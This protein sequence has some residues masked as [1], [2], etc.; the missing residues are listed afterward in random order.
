MRPTKEPAI[1]TVADVRESPAGDA[2]EV[3]F[4]ERQQIYSLPS[5]VRAREAVH[6]RLRE[7]LE[8]SALVKV[9]LNPRRGVVE[10]VTE[11]AEREVREFDKLRIPLENPEKR[12][13]STSPG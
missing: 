4:N 3:L 5:A 7:A 9:T 13:G 8:R 11:P 10:R 6:G 1:L 2:I 12:C